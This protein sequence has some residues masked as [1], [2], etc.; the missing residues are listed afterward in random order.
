MDKKTFAYLLLATAACGSSDAAPAAV[1]V[2]PP[3]S[4]PP[5]APPATTTQPPAASAPPPAPASHDYDADGTTAWDKSIAHVTSPARAF[6]VTVWMP[7]TAGPHPV[8]SFSCGTNQTAAGYAPYAQRLASWG[9]ASVLRDDPGVTVNTTQV[10]EDAAYVVATWMPSA[11]AGKADLARVGLVGHS[12]GGAAS[13]LAA[14]HGLKGKIAAWFG[15]DPVD[16]EF[17]MNPGAYA[18]TDI[19]AIGVPTAYL[20]ADVIGSC[21]PAAD[22]YQLLYPK[23]P[24]PSALI[25]GKGAG[26]EQLEPASSCS[27]CGVCSPAGTAD[28]KVVL[29]YSVRYLTAFFARE[30][31]GDKSVG[32]AFE[33]AG[34]AADIAAGRVTVTSK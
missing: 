33:G 5:G 22:G 24:S 9:I 23:S 11:L 29:A 31:L 6:D 3:P 19:G 10:V 30:L 27:A 21:N 20:G 4:P 14:E 13:L 8:V 26:H 15:L 34:A 28:G 32:A 16:N 12:R 18:R 25:V 17:L 1:D 2:V 7:K